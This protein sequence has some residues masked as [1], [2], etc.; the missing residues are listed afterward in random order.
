MFDF[1]KKP[2][3]DVRIELPSVTIEF[4]H[5]TKTVFMHVDNPN[6]TPDAFAELE[7]HFAKRGYSLTVFA[8]S[9]DMTAKRLPS[10]G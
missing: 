10:P 2:Q 8:P 1:L 5:R 4:N 6:L 7:A 3:Q 9:W